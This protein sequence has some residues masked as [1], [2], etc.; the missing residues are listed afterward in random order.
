M[1]LIFFSLKE[2]P[3]FCKYFYVE[4]LSFT[5]HFWLS[6]EPKLIGINEFE[7]NPIEKFEANLYSTLKKNFCFRNT[8]QNAKIK[9]RQSSPRHG[10]EGSR[11]HRLA[12]AVQVPASYKTPTQQQK[13]KTKKK[14]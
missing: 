7:K 2:L 14:L 3:Q 9:I 8:G 12:S 13:P 5:H 1:N 10:R 6:K 4:F 11:W